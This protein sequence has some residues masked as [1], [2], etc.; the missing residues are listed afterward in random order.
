L[1]KSFFMKIRKLT[2][3]DYDAYFSLRLESLQQC[4]AMYATDANDWQAAPRGVIEKHLVLSESDQSPILSAWHGDALVGLIGLMV[5]TRPTV[6]HK[7]TLW[8]FYVL[9]AIRRQ[10]VGQALVQSIISAANMVPHLEQLRAV[11]AVDGEGVM[12]FFESCGFREYGREPRAKCLAGVYHD[13][14]Y[15]W[16]PLANAEN[17]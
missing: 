1:L 17:R 12:R 6:R 2:T 11:V 10:G 13:Q 5:D 4:P 8:G 9:P 15:F 14:V 16:Y 3:N 7:A